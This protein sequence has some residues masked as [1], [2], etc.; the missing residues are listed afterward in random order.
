MMLINNDDF[1][2][3]D[4]SLSL[5]NIGDIGD[6]DSI[7]IFAQQKRKAW[8]EDSTDLARCD[9]QPGRASLMLRDGSFRSISLWRRSV[10]GMSLTEIKASD[11]MIPFFVGHMS[12]F[13]ASVLGDKL[14]KEHFAIVAPP[15][16]RH[17]RRNFASIV[18]NGI[19]QNL[20]IN[21][22]D[23]FAQCKSRQR[24]NAVFTADF[25]PKEHNIIVFDDFVTTG[26]TLIAMKNLLDSLNRN[27]IFFTGVLNKK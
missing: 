5:Q 13:I 24:V 23:N 7:D 3:P 18:A 11:D 12:Q 8:N 22:Y 15:K 2:F 6:S 10:K 1:E 16:R 20:G 26:S 17:K 14:C 25:V 19:A 21:F 27:S 4:I 9:F